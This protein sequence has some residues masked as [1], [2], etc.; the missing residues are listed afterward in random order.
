V[1]C[2]GDQQQTRRLFRWLGRYRITEPDRVL[3]PYDFDRF[4][5]LASTRTDD[6]GNALADLFTGGSVPWIIWGDSVTD[7]QDEEYNPN[8][9]EMQEP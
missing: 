9:G 8:D 4:K 2:P 7:V 3:G 1:I 6:D 5:T